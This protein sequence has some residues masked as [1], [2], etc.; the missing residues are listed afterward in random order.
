MKHKFAILIFAISVLASLSTITAQQQQA[1]HQPV[2]WQIQIDAVNDAFKNGLMSQADYDARMKQLKSAAALQDAFENGLLTPR[3]YESKLLALSGGTSAPA[4]AAVNITSR[5]RWVEVQDPAWGIVVARFQ[6]P[7]DWNF[8]GTVI[9]DDTCSLPPALTWRISSPD[10]LYGAQMMPD[11]GSYWATNPSKMENFR[12][13]HCKLMEP[14]RP[15]EFLQYAAPLVRPDPILGSV[16]PSDDAE[17]WQQQIDHYNQRA[18]AAFGTAPDSGGAVCSRIQFAYRGQTIEE[19]FAV[20]QQ[21]FKTKDIWPRRPEFFT[22]TTYAKVRTI[23]APKGQLDDVMSILRPM[24]AGAYEPTPEWNQR[25]EQKLA[26]DTA[27]NQAILQQQTA[28]AQAQIM[29]Q[30][31][32]L[33]NMLNTSNANFQKAQNDRFNSGQQQW[34]QHMDYMNRSALA[35]TLYAGDNQLVRNPQTGVVSTVTNKYGTSAYQQDGTNNILLQNPNDINP[36][37]YLRGTYTQLE[38]IDPM[39]FQP[40]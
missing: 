39:K 33:R 12:R 8:D 34:Q 24:L 27:R 29:Q 25:F 38:N 40:Q 28:A 13:N 19:Y 7:A 5:T 2:N 9:R 10:G 20:R 18:M 30:A 36:N 23:R 17:Y 21:T 32:D 31:G 4:P 1:R 26:S 37:L 15:E 35:Y 16:G 14:L 6:I 22:W 11:F 3:E